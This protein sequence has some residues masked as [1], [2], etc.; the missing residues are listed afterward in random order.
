MQGLFKNYG[1]RTKIEL[2]SQCINFVHNIYQKNTDES[3]NKL[4]LNFIITR[5][6][7]AVKILVITYTFAAIAFFLNPLI[8][9]V[10]FGE[11]TLMLPAQLPGVNDKTVNGLII[12]TCFHL[13]A[14]NYAF[15]GSI[16]TD[17]GYISI[18][19]NAFAIT[20]LIGNEFKRLDKMI[21][22]RNLYSV[23]HI[24]NTVRNIIIMHQDFRK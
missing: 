6:Y 19:L 20:E 1:W 23:K 18:L 10:V 24:K 13:I 5:M 9:Y 22:K 16:G 2:I 12:L 7:M 21:L 4:T 8:H 17:L 11:I 15:F 3:D 14:V